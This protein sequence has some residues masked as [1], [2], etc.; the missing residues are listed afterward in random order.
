[1]S[2]PPECP[3]NTFPRS[4]A[5]G[6]RQNLALGRGEGHHRHLRRREVRSRKSSQSLNRRIFK[7][8]GRAFRYIEFRVQIFTLVSGELTPMLWKLHHIFYQPMAHLQ[9]FWAVKMTAPFPA[10]PVCLAKS[11]LRAAAGREVRMFHH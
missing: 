2:L 9:H 6:L 5:L 3:N 1:M 11:A 10:F 4:K 7:A 8:C